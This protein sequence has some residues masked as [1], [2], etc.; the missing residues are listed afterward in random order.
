MALVKRTCTFQNRARRAT[1][2]AILNAIDDFASIDVWRDTQDAETTGKGA[3]RS[4]DEASVQ[5]SRGGVE[6]AESV[7]SRE[8]GNAADGIDKADSGGN[9][10]GTEDFRG[11]RPEGRQIDDS[12]CRH[13]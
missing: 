13:D 3:Q 6:V 11:D 2:E 1:R 12:R 9:N 8:T 7:R 5:R 10:R 4:Q